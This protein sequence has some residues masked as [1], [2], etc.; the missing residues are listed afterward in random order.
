[1][2]SETTALCYKTTEKKM[3][4]FRS[5]PRKSKVWRHINRRSEYISRDYNHWYIFS[6]QGQM[7]CSRTSH[8]ILNHLTSHLLQH[9][10]TLIHVGFHARTSYRWDNSSNLGS[11]IWVV[12]VI[13]LYWAGLWIFYIELRSNQRAITSLAVVV[14]GMVYSDWKEYTNRNAIGIDSFNC[15]W[16]NSIIVGLLLL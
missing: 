8:K 2:I 15:I 16:C 10:I 1:M 5:Q 14:C 4:H 11:G 13:F 9:N 3:L 7:V 12:P 6:Q